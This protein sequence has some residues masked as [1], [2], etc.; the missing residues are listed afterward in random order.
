MTHW[1]ERP[2]TVALAAAILAA[3]ISVFDRLLPHDVPLSL[4]YLLPMGMIGS[5]ASRWQVLSAALLCTGIAE[6]SDAF[7]WSASAG[8]PRDLL[9]FI[10]FASEGLY[11]REALSK[12]QSE[13]RNIK[14]LQEENQARR[15]AEE[16]LSLLIGSSALA[17]LT[18]DGTGL[19]I[20][21]NQAA[22][23]MFQEGACGDE[24]LLG[25]GVTTLLPALGRVPHRSHP[26]RPVKTMM[27][28][29][30]FRRD[31]APFLAEVWF[32][33]YTTT[34]GPRT[35]AMIVDASDDLRDR[36]ESALEQ[37]LNSSR[38][39]VGAVAH[40]IRNVSS[41]IQLVQRNLLTTTPAL[42]DTPDFIALQQLTSTLERMASV[43][44]SQVKRT[45]TILPLQH[46]FEE[47]RIVS[48][49][50]LRE[51][52]IALEWNV[53]ADLPSAWADQQGLMQ[54][55]LNILRN[56]QS[57]LASTADAKVRVD[58]IRNAKTVSIRISDN[59]PGVA[60]PESLFRPFWAAPT[61]V[62]FGLYLSRAILN[63]F[64]ADISY[65]PLNP[66]ASFVIALQVASL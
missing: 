10:A 5:V 6:Y 36:E 1:R 14:L 17:I 15:E 61:T 30:G 16:Q 8:I 55:F 50:M 41:A 7:A 28:T 49:A 44:T 33:T 27:Q 9:S 52:D 53:P 63:S 26:E 25:I 32:S 62:S 13:R 3:A 38:L 51:S 39:A 37:L 11:I 54:V 45:A 47:L 21:A 22:R 31:G 34:H 23:Q 64:Q 42:G 58:F 29:Q 4:L 60:T 48:Q 35:A 57:A 19:I 20:Q 46:C 40:E 56:A 2:A 66:G 24:S 59:G 43:E 65:E 18:L 12:R